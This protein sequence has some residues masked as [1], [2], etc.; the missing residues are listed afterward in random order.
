MKRIAL[1]VLLAL[2]FFSSAAHADSSPSTYNLSGSLTIPGNS[3]CN[4]SETIFFNFDVGGIIINDANGPNAP[5]A[6]FFG[7][8]GI[9]IVPGSASV[10]SSGPLSF[11]GVGWDPDESDFNFPNSLGDDIEMNT[12]GF[13]AFFFDCVSATCVR[14]FSSGNGFEF[15]GP[16][17][18]TV[19]L[20]PE[21]NILLMLMCGTALLGILKFIPRLGARDRYRNRNVEF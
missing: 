15:G 8:P 2:M 16:S 1:V 9:F 20:V 7:T 17:N 6:P 10:S 18:V 13:T 4:C 11:F 12:I 19:R 14:D 3:A 5:P 21:P